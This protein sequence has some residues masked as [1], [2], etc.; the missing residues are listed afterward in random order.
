[1]RLSLGDPDF[2]NISAVT[3]ALLSDD[4]MAG[5]QRG[6]SDYAVLPELDLY[7]GEFNLKFAG[8]NDAGTTHLSVM[9]SDGNA[10]SI[11]STINTHFGSKVVSPSTGILFNNEMDDFSI[12]GVPNNYG[13]FP[14]KSNY[15]E[16]FKRPLSS[17]SPS[18]I[19]GRSRTSSSG[20]VV[21]MIGGA[22]GGPKIIT[23]TAQII[24]NCL[25][26]GMGL[27]DSFKAPRIHSQL[28]PDLV[29]VENQTCASGLGLA[30]PTAMRFALTSRGHAISM[31]PDD[32]GVAQFI[33]ETRHP[34][35]CSLNRF[36]SHFHSHSFVF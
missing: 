33:G 31:V 3:A 10:V 11:T 22:S 25:G 23:A 20:W 9:D 24:L 12:P 36:H 29:Q 6:T 34:R 2:V 21:R 30:G 26:L 16:P 8:T 7:G 35:S 15:P 32:M 4:Y 28:L 27:L 13:L 14:S 5:L 18:I 19:L 1:M 17:M